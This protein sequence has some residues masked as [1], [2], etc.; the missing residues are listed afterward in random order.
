M[1][2]SKVTV[3]NIMFIYCTKI[4]LGPNTKL[5]GWVPPT[6]WKIFINGMLFLTLLFEKLKTNFWHEKFKPPL[7]LPI[8][9]LRLRIV[10]R[11]SISSPGWL[12]TIIK[13]PLNNNDPQIV[14]G[15]N[16]KAVYLISSSAVFAQGLFLKKIF[17]LNSELAT[18]LKSC[19]EISCLDFKSH[20][21]SNLK[22]DF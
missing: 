6:L 17:S 18:E 19:G 21:F 11:E 20:D 15:W 5:A 16:T 7:I 3:S 12:Q 4:P 22:I 9:L 14:T 8:P 2:Q 13:L 10:L 1:L